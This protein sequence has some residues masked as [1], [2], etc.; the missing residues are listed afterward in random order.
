MIAGLRIGSHGD[1]RRQ[2]CGRR[3]VAFHPGPWGHS[4]YPRGSGDAGVS[5]PELLVTIAIFMIV[6]T[7]LATEFS[8]WLT[9]SRITQDRSEAMA[10]GRLA[11]AQLT[12]ALR[13]AVSPTAAPAPFVAAGPFSVTFYDLT[14]TTNVANPHRVTYS[15][16]SDGNITETRTTKSGVVLKGPVSIAHFIANPMS[17]PST[18]PVFRYFEVTPEGVPVELP[19]S[20]AQVALSP[21]EL[22]LIAQVSITL[23]TDKD[24]TS[25]VG[26][27]V[28]SETIFVRQRG[29]SR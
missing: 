27:T 17:G 28:M 24:T 20:S 10:E 25:E 16:S 12:R 23:I 21:S 19:S 5:L 2:K 7:M 9:N 26:R 4:D 6:G 15:L 13:E 29:L 11:M 8:S 22:P 14:G 3:R 18:T 1:N